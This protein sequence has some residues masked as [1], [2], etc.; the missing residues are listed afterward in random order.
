MF[1]INTA[2]LKWHRMFYNYK[3]VSFKIIENSNVTTLL[4][5]DCSVSL[6]KLFPADDKR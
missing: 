3:N 2:L 6:I 5:V 1:H 4:Y